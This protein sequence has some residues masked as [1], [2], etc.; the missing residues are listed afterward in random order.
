MIVRR[1][2]VRLLICQIRSSQGMGNYDVQGKYNVFDCSPPRC[3]VVSSWDPRCHQ[4]TKFDG[5][6]EDKIGRG[7]KLKIMCLIWEEITGGL[8]S[9]FKAL[10]LATW[11]ANR[12]GCSVVRRSLTLPLWPSKIAAIGRQLAVAFW[13]FR[14]TFRTSYG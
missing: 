1:G 8:G 14:A 13:G 3:T 10:Y 9:D 12:F 2:E 6:R 7:S 5:R 11:V 4:R